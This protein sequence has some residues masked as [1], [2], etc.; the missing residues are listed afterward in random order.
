M[1]KNKCEEKIKY[2]R[3]WLLLFFLLT[4]DIII[5]SDGSLNLNSIRSVL[6][7][8]CLK[9][10]A[11]HRTFGSFITFFFL[12]TYQKNLPKNKTKMSGP[13][14]SSGCCC[15]SED[16]AVCQ[17]GLLIRERT[18]GFSLLNGSGT[19]HTFVTLNSKSP[20]HPPVG[21]FLGSLSLFSSKNKCRRFA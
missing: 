10:F 14:R 6:R 19:G 16:A 21:Q 4:R 12:Q 8:S 2:I 18:K 3:V 20:P 17:S 7:N 15:V 13:I 11:I 1:K 5:I 9:H